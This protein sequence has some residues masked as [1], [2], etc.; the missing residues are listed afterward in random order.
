MSREKDI[1]YLKILIL[2]NTLIY[3]KIFKY[4]MNADL[5]NSWQIFI[6]MG[7]KWACESKYKTGHDYMLTQDCNS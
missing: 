1:K 5:N 4:K 2:K 7:V 6:D 3:N